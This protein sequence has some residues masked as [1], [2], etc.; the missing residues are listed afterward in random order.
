MSLGRRVAALPI[1]LASLVALGC[2]A[3]GGSKNVPAHYSQT[4]AGQLLQ[5]R[6]E[7]CHRVPRPERMTGQEWQTALR[8]MKRRVTLPAA[9]WDS[10]ATLG[11]SDTSISAPVR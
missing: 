5:H 8:R 1:V 11:L 10:L 7:G 6:C 3:G 4:Y 9:D 2:A